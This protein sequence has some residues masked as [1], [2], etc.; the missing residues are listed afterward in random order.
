MDHADLCSV[1]SSLAPGVVLIISSEYCQLTSLLQLS[2]P[3]HASESMLVRMQARACVRRIGVLL[4]GFRDH[5]LHWFAQQ[6]PLPESH[7]PLNLIL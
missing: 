7:W 3:S 1:L 4:S 6:V 2:F 5:R